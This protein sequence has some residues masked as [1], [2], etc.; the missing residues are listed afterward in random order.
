LAKGKSYLET[1]LYNGE[2]FYQKIMTD[3]L[4]AKFTPLK[5]TE[6]G[7]GY[8]KISSAIN[9]QGPRCQ[10]GTG[11]LS[12]GVVGLWMAQ[13]CGLRGEVVDAA[14]VRS[15]LGAVYKYNMKHDLSDFANPQRP[16]YA[17]GHEGGLLICTWPKGDEQII[18]FD[19]SNEVFTGVEYYVAGFMIANGMVKEGLDI[20]R[21]CRDR[22]DGRVRNPFD[23]YECGHWYG[24]ALSSYGLL[25]ALTGVRYDAVEKTLYIDSKVG[26]TFTT[27]FAAASGFGNIGLKEGKPFVKMTEG[28]LEIDKVIVSGK[29]AEDWNK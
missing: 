23:E 12:D 5:E 8:Q 14:K 21:T 7:E 6:S 4:N 11:C 10:Y 24:R 1:D 29:I 13:M 20:V 28:R 18:P 19:Y 9:H 26:D 3:G 15:H 22:Y 16:N 2:Y 27:F 25:Q 17:L